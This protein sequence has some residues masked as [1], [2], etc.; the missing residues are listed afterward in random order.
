MADHITIT[1]DT[2]AN[3]A[4]VVA[5]IADTFTHLT[6]V[7]ARVPPPAYTD[8]CG[9]CREDGGEVPWRVE[10][11]VATVYYRSTDSVSLTYRTGVCFEHLAQE[12]GYQARQ[13]GRAAVWVE[14]P[15][16][17]LAGLAVSA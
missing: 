15:T 8:L 6:P 11:A 7:V 9:L 2:A 12:Y 14:V 4:R 16:C 5:E 10:D 13:P 1:P 3:V 17:E